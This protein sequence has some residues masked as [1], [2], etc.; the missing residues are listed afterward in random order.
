MQNVI[1]SPTLNYTMHY[2]GTTDCYT[3]WGWGCSLV[4]RASD[5]HAAD[6]GSI[7]RCGMGFFS[8]SQLS[9]QTLLRCMYTPVR[10]RMY[11]QMCS[12]KDPVVHVRVWW[13]LETLKRP[14]CTIGWIARLSRSWL[15]PG[16]ASRICH[17]RYPRGSY[18]MRLKLCIFFVE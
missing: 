12:L 6:P 16:K 11:L 14:A 9:V 7:P 17:G 10:N 1:S 8:Q 3:V 18:L 5:R 4:G 15:S 2:Y 13:I